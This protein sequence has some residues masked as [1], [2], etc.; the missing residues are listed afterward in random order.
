MGLGEK[1]VEEVGIVKVDIFLLSVVEE[2]GFYGW[3]CCKVVCFVLMRG[4]FVGFL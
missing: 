4:I 1:G 3:R 2:S